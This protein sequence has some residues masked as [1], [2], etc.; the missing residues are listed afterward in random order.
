M[1]G[2]GDGDADADARDTVTQSGS[3]VL[4]NGFD[5]RF[6]LS[7][8]GCPFRPF[9]ICTLAFAGCLL[10]SHHFCRSELAAG[11]PGSTASYPNRSSSSDSP[12]SAMCAVVS[13][14]SAFRR[15]YSSL[16]IADRRFSS[17]ILTV[18]SNVAYTGLWSE[19]CSGAESY[20]SCRRFDPLR[21]IRSVHAGIRAFS[22]QNC[23]Y[24]N[25]AP[26]LTLLTS[27][28]MCLLPDRID[29]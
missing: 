20:D 6:G 14:I 4:P 5:G 19:N 9:G 16:L 8:I 25:Y 29:T 11:R 18:Q 21:R 23:Q 15:W 28:R 3:F 27:Y 2:D 13:P 12:P 10:S 7:T 26:F 24:L 17:T 22:L 1:D